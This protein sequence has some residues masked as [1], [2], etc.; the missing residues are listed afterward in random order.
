MLS[1]VV[2]KVISPVA[3]KVLRLYKAKRKGKRGFERA[4][5]V[6]KLLLRSGT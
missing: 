4:E 5:A 1:E 6:I 2:M 3:I